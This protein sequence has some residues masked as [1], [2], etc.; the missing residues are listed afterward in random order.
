MITSSSTRTGIERKARQKRSHRAIPRPSTPPKAALTPLSSLGARKVPFSYTEDCIKLLSLR[1]LEG[2]ERVTR[3]FRGA[4]TIEDHKSAVGDPYLPTHILAIC[5]GRR[6][7][8][9]DGS[10]SSPPVMIQPTHRYILTSQCTNLPDIPDKLSFSPSNHTVDAIP[11]HLPYPKLFEPL[12]R[13]L[14]NHN[15]TQLLYS[16]L[17]P[18]CRTNIPAGTKAYHIGPC[19]TSCSCLVSLLSKSY[20]KQDLTTCLIGLVAFKENVTSLGVHDHN[21]WRVMKLASFVLRLA[22]S[23][24][25]A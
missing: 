13:Y 4:G 17:P 7:H 2:V 20:T 11:L 12:H 24:S 8:S 10:T 9:P 25:V 1:L 18:K 23:V 16:F 21:L 19:S 14:Y 6:N 22:I 5:D 15:T 3:V